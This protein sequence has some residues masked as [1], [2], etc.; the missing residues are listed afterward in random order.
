MGF[1]PRDHQVHEVA[2]RGNQV[3]RPQRHFL[4]G[5]LQLQLAVEAE[6]ADAPEAIAVHVVELFVEQR[7][8]LFELR[9]VA[10][11]QPLVDSEQ[12]LFVAGRGI[13]CQA[14]EEQ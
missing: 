13:I 12:G 14:V 3:L 11:T 2:N 1:G 6:A 5:R 7:L 10:G 9:R 8:C 4:L